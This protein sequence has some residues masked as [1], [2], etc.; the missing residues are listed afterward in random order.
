MEPLDDSTSSRRARV[1]VADD[2]ADMR[3]VRVAPAGRPYAW[4][5]RRT[6]SRR[7]SRARRRA[8]DLILADVMMPRLDGFGL[9]RSCGRIRG[10]ATCR[11]SCCRRG[12]ARRARIEGLEAGAD[13][14]L[15][16]PFAAKELLA[17]VAA[18]IQIAR[19]RRESAREQQRLR[20]DA[21]A[22]KGRLEEADRRKDE[23]LATLAHELR[24]PLAPLRNGLADHELIGND[25]EAVR[26]SRAMMERQLEQMVRLVDD[27]LDVSRISRGKIELRA[28]A[29]RARDRGPTAPSR[30][31]GR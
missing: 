23:F 26:A 12:P 18:H 9:L 2:N 25:G 22:A 11:S 24:N 31:A 16:K 10:R 17:R 27:L 21:E 29:R 8:P 14:Y 6:A 19:I 7:S 20:A 5:P 13:D 3:A 4:K 1:L 28:R 30:P 15:V